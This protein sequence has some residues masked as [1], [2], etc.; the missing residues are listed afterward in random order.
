M[1]ARIQPDKQQRDEFNEYIKRNFNLYAERIFQCWAMAMNDSGDSTD[2]VSDTAKKAYKLMTEIW[3]EKTAEIDKQSQN[4]KV[5]VSDHRCLQQSFDNLKGL[6]DEEKAKAESAK[7]KSI[8]F[9]KELQK[10][11]AEIN[12]VTALAA[13][14]KDA[15]YTYADNIDKAKAEAIKAFVERLKSEINVRTTLSKEQ[16]KIILCYIDNLVKEMVGDAE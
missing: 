15:A 16:D 10:A 8:Y 13:E 9:A 7:S 6:Y 14:W 12:R 1:K 3:K 11:R 4:F 5:L 2:K